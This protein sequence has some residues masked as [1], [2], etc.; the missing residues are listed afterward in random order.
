M[1]QSYV[2]REILK[3]GGQPVLREGIK[4]DNGNIILDIHHL[5]ITHPAEMEQQIDGIVGV[6]TNGL[7]ARR[8]AD[9]LL[10]ADDKGVTTLP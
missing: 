7:F 10:L 4:T 1:A 9:V 8:P 2:A 3:M 6:L 5:S